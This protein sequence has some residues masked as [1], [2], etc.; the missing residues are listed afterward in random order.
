MIYIASYIKVT[1]V[2]TNLD[3]KQD[4]SNYSVVFCVCNELLKCFKG[5]K[6]ICYSNQDV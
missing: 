2:Y 3:R 6:S 5:A 4:Q 1:L